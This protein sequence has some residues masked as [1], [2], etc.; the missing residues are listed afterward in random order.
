MRYGQV[1]YS[2]VVLWWRFRN[3]FGLQWEPI[4]LAPY[5]AAAAAA[6]ISLWFIAGCLGVA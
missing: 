6:Q 4:H 2:Q 3:E 5:F 1:G